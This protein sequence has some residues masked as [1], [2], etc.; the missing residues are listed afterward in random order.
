LRGTAIPLAPVGS[1][2]GGRR[3]AS[4]ARYHT[5]AGRNPYAALPTVWILPIG[6]DMDPGLR[7]DDIGMFVRLEVGDE[8]GAPVDSNASG[9]GGGAIVEYSDLSVATLLLADWIMSASA[10]VPGQ[11]QLGCVAGQR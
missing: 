4:P 2:R 6:T 9:F 1:E 5:G 10:V 7:R 3:T 8:S 11:L